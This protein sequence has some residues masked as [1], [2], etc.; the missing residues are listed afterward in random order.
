MIVDLVQKWINAII[1]PIET[2]KK[3]KSKADYKQAFINYALAGLIAGI[4]LCISGVQITSSGTWFG[5]K[6]VFSL[7][8]IL[9]TLIEIIIFA[10]IAQA[11][12]FALSKLIKGKGN[13]KTQFYLTSLFAVGI[14]GLNLALNFIGLGI[15]AGI[16]GLILTFFAIKETHDFPLWKAFVVAIIIP[17]TVI[18]L[19]MLTFLATMF[20]LPAPI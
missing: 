8:T 20:A 10:L 1:H 5:N 15:F 3:E 7:E 12:L 16:Y 17:I 9:V 4:M 19:I 2:F 6:P 11:I 13:Y 18:I 14:A